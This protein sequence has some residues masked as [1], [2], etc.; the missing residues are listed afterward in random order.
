MATSKPFNKYTIHVYG[1][2]NI[3]AR[4]T[5]YQDSNWVGRIDFYPDGMYMPVDYL[6]HPTSNPSIEAIILNMPMSRFESVA[7]IVR[8]EEPLWLWISISPGGAGDYTRELGAYGMLHTGAEPVGED[9]N[10]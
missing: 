6:Y 8:T 4:L 7:T 10:P 2:V 1:T 3:S 9:E 5:C